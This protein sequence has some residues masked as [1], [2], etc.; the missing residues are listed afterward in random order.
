MDEP[1]GALDTSTRLKMQDFLA[2][3]WKKSLQDMTIIFVT[4]DI[5]E[6]VY[7]AD[8]VWIM[9]ANPGQISERLHIDI[10]ISRAKEMKRTKQFMDYVYYLEDKLNG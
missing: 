4:H 5:P 8:E 9:S 7:L 1:F 10:P 6:A 3:I 2:D